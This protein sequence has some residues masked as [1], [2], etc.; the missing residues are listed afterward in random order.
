MLSANVISFYIW[1]KRGGRDS[2]E[3]SRGEEEVWE[4]AA[5]VPE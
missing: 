4:Q 1:G 2:G 5:P 3:G